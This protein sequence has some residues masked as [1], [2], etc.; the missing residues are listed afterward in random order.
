MCGVSRQGRNDVAIVSR[1]RR[2]LGE[3]GASRRGSER[4]ND[5]TI[6][7]R[8][9]CHLAGREREQKRWRGTGEAGAGKARRCERTR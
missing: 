9:R 5:V 2:R 7:S 4:G 8:R 3:R 1:R 6:A